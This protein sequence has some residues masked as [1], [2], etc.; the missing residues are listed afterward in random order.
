MARIFYPSK[1]PIGQRLKWGATPESPNPWMTV[2]GVV[3]D[4]KQESLHETTMPMTFTPLAQEPDPSVA[5][6]FG[7]FRAM[8]VAVRT[9]GDP[10][11]VVSAVRRQIAEIDPALPVSDLRTMEETIRESAAPQR[12]STSM[13]GA[14]A[15]LALLL[16]TL[17]IAGVVAYSAAQ[18]TREIGLRIALGAT[19]VTI[20]RLALREGLLYSALGLLAGVGA[21]LGLTRLMGSLLYGVPANDPMTFAG[22]ITLIALVAALASLLPAYRATRVNPVQALRQE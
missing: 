16:A 8:N 3:A 13:L 4:I 12:F 11:A 5:H 18:R 1:D 21:A 9:S 10:A 7:F 19:R 20:L 6:P 2:V 22:V 15:A 14:F 17:G